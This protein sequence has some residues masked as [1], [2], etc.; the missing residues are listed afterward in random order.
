VNRL[1]AEK[2]RGPIR[3]K[4]KKK[5]QKEYWPLNQLGGLLLLENHAAKKGKRDLG[6]TLTKKTQREACKDLFRQ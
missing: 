3:E 4:K 6:Q 1:L 2:E 5:F